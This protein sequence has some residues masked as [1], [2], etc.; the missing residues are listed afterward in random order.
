MRMRKEREPVNSPPPLASKA[1][2]LVTPRFCRW[3]A[4]VY[5]AALRRLA[6]LIYDS[7][8]VRHRRLEERREGYEFLVRFDQPANVELLLDEP[9]LLGGGRGPNSPA[10]SRPRWRIVYR[11][12]SA[13]APAA[14]SSKTRG[15]YATWRRHGSKRLPRSRSL[16]SGPCAARAW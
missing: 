10:W 13:S 11:R 2:L 6:S 1:F 9:P 14:S 16:P 8:A 7:P 12:V 15:R 5:I 4:G 3:S